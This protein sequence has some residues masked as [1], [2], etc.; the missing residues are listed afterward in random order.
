MCRS[1]PTSSGCGFST[2][3]ESARFNRDHRWR[4]LFQYSVKGWAI[5]DAGVVDS[6]S[7]RPKRSQP[8]AQKWRS[9]GLGS[10]NVTLITRSRI[11][12][13]P[14]R[15]RTGDHLIAAAIASSICAPRP[16]TPC[17]DY[18]FRARISCSLFFRSRVYPSDMPT[19][20]CRL[21]VGLLSGWS[22][23]AASSVRAWPTPL[24]YE[25]L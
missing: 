24:R 7:I 20:E 12:A 3:K 14:H 22:S 25:Q 8:S 5:E 23:C 21:R 18:Y 9:S 16:P 17:D 10:G 13:S 2:M 11:V 15:T 4:V 19:D 6:V 1:H